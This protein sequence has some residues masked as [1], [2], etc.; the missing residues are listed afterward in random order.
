[1]PQP[2]AADEPKADA[3]LGREGRQGRD[4]D[5]ASK[6]AIPEA[7]LELRSTVGHADAQQ[8]RTADASG[9]T[10]P[11]TPSQAAMPAAN[12]SAA[13]AAGD[14]NVA[15]PRSDSKAGPEMQ[16]I[17]KRSHRKQPGRRQSR[18]PGASRQT[19]TSR[20]EHDRRPMTSRR[21]RSRVRRG[22]SDE[23]VIAERR[24]DAE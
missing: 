3:P 10:R 2:V 12:A 21:R 11:S 6:P 15:M 9:R 8:T 19:E 14:A 20:L 4:A 17:A 22:R 5:T 24:E 1:M 7:K 13:T 23:A 18:E 16:T